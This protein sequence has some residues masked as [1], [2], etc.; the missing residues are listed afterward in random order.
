MYIYLHIHMLHRHIS[1][2]SYIIASIM[3]CVDIKHGFSINKKI[4]SCPIPRITY[5]SRHFRV[6]DFPFFSP[7]GE[8][9]LMVQKSQGQ[10][11]D[12]YETLEIMGHSPYQLVSRISSI[13]RMLRPW[14]GPISPRHIISGAHLPMCPAKRS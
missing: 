6:H 5:P 3:F 2:T 8:I 13:N 14:R 11:P 4:W 9:R 7:F 12:M 1:G 10:P